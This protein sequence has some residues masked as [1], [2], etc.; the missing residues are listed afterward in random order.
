M[1]GPYPEKNRRMASQGPS[2]D[3]PPITEQSH[4]I[5]IKLGGQII[6]CISEK[7]CIG[8]HFRVGL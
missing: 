3:L 5:F 7:T 4:V 8:N 1:K 2:L 6:N